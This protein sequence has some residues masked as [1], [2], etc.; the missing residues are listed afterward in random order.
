MGLIR[1]RLWRRLAA[2]MYDGFLLLALYFILGWVLVLLNDGAAVE[3]PWMFW[4]LIFVAWAFFA[5]FWCYPGQ[6]LGM[7]VW[8]MKLV[9]ENDQAVTLRQASVRFLLS[10]VSWAAF[11]LGF[12]WCL[13]DKDGRSWHDKLSQT[14]LV[15]IDHKKLKEGSN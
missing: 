8:K 15:Y 9:S 4:F 14:K 3:G 10:L 5:K 11:G 13:V 2:A 7:Q 6:T 1:I 12:L